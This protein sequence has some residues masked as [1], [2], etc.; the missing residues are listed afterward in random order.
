M[1]L[2]DISSLRDRA[3]VIAGALLSVL[4]TVSRLDATTVYDNGGPKTS[5]TA[6]ASD[7]DAGTTGNQLACDFI[8]TAGG[9]TVSQVNWWG[10]YSAANT[11]PAQDDF[12][13]RIFADAGGVPAAN[14]LNHY[15]VANAVNRTDSGLN[16]GSRDIYAFSAYIPA[17]T[18]P[19]GTTFWLSVVN[20]TTADTDDNW[21]WVNTFSITGNPNAGRFNDGEAWLASSSDFAFNLTDAVPEPATVGLLALAAPAILRRRRRGNI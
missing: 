11:P 13:V 15:P 19:A 7:F 17:T 4:V 5:G 2:E 1:L 20:D 8:L 21:A 10:I 3:V 18:L 12:I 16:F 14:P 9:T 6:S